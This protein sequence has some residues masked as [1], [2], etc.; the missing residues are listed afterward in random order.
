MFDILT[1]LPARK[2]TSPSGWVSF[3][4]VCCTHNGETKDKR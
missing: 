1:I 4:A 3:N 2:K